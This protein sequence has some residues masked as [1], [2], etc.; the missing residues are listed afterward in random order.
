VIK[1]NVLDAESNMNNINEETPSKAANSVN[2]RCED[3]RKGPVLTRFVTQENVLN[4]SNIAATDI[5][6]D[7]AKGP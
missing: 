5:P 4:V 6:A 2:A 7:N 3:L 1:A